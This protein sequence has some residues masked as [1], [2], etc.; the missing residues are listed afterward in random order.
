MS[1]KKTFASISSGKKSRLCEKKKLI[2][3]YEKAASRQL[4]LH[5]IEKP[6][7]RVWMI[8]IPILFVFYFWKVKEYEKGLQDFAE[9]YLIPRR[10]ALEAACAAAESCLPVNVDVLVNQFDDMQETTRALCKEWLTV[11]TGHFQLLLN[12]EG[13][14]YH[15]LVH[16]GYR[17]KSG[18]LQ[19]CQHADRTETAFNL[20]LLKTIDGDSTALCQV[21]AAMKEG[22][23]SLQK[24]SAENFFT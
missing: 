2:L 17:D 24:Q 6:L 12:A 18:Y 15:K 9:N 21:T 16:S 13:D 4:A 20:A 1:D 8:F 10:R 5:V 22:M 23:R 7:P 3:E 19:F 14:S 11:L